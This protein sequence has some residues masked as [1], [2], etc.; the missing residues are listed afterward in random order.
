MRE[1]IPATKVWVSGF[2]RKQRSEI[3]KLKRQQ[4]ERVGMNERTVT[5][6]LGKNKQLI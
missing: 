1:P 6:I 3:D 2:E 5:H 4:I